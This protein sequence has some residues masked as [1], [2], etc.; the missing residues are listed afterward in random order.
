MLKAV[1]SG[2]AGFVFAVTIGLGSA[3]AGPVPVIGSIDK[4]MDSQSANKNLIKVSGCHSNRRRHMVYKWG[5]KSWHR[6]ASNCQPRHVRPS[7]VRRHCHR[8]Y[9]KHR[10]A[11]RGNRWHRHVGRRCHYQRGRVGRRHN[12]GGCVRIA[13]VWICSN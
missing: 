4:A 7:R 9:R 2:I 1:L 12:S 6:H 11:G 10:H 5:Y 3:V 13:G 8:G